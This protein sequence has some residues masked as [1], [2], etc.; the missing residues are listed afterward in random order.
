DRPSWTVLIPQTRKPRHGKPTYGRKHTPPPQ[1][2]APPP[3]ECTAHDRAQH[4]TSYPDTAATPGESTRPAVG[5][6]PRPQKRPQRRKQP[7]GQNYPPAQKQGRTDQSLPDPH[8]RHAPHNPP[9][10]HPAPL[11]PTPCRTPPRSP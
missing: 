6:A 4:S 1:A 7:T 10:P 11:V 3:C 9:P 8:A 5:A 2:H